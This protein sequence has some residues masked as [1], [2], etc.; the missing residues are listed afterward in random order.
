M[1]VLIDHHTPFQLAHGG[2]QTQIEQTLHALG[3]I[4]I[5]AECLRWWDESQTGD[6]VH[7]FGRPD[8]SYIQ[9][10]HGKGMKVVMLELLT[11]LGSR[12][13]AARFVQKSLLTAA[14]AILPRAFTARLAWDS[15][16]LAD[17]CIANTV[18]EATLMKSIF[19]ATP[20]KVHVV[21]NGVEAEFLESTP[22]E[23]GQWL[24]CS[25]T[26]TERKRMLELA[27]AA[28]LAQAP[29]R[30]IGKPYANT[31]PY[32]ERFANLVK[33]HPQW[34]R[35]EGPINDRSK[36][37]AAYRE[38]RG[39]ILL[40]TMET[41]SLAAE[42]AS[43]CECPLLLSDLP[44]ARSVFGSKASYCPITT[45]AKTAAILRQFYEAA[46][47]LPRPARPVSWVEVAHQFQAIYG[48]VLHTS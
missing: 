48:Q 37:A 15:Y 7:F 18:W 46:S 6:L 11:G 23:R 33:K 28:V 4:G 20:K 22:R 31:D 1:K 41:R 32:A 40:S 13:A 45:T 35:H 17:A 19:R 16:Q 21:P 43:A 39:F 10:A 25:G 42:E 27:E 47:A 14:Q 12:G 30:F 2:L 8:A 3:A 9:F 38:A 34:L 44:W 24:V 29:V 5:D 36:L 26:I